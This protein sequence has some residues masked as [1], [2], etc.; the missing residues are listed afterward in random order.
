MVMSE[1]VLLLHLSDIH[2]R[3]SSDAILSRSGEIAA[4]TFKRLPEIT[5]VLMIVSGDIAYGGKKSEYDLATEFLANIAKSIRTQKD[6]I[7]VEVFVCPGN[8][9]CDFD[10]DDDTREAVLAKIRLSDSAPSESLIKTATSIQQA[11]FEFRDNVSAFA[12]VHASPMSWQ[13]VIKVGNHRIG[14]RS[15]NVAWMSEIKEK[16]GTLIFPPSEISPFKMREAD[17]SITILHHPYNWFGQSSYRA[18]Q[19][20]V[21]R[22]SQIVFTG[23]EHV[24]NVGEVSDSRNS[25]SVFVEGG[26]L[27]ESRLPERSTFNTI[28]VDLAKAEYLSELYSWDGKRYAADDDDEIWGSLRPLTVESEHKCSLQPMFLETLKDPGANFSHSSKKNLELDDFYIWPELQYLDDKATIKK[29]VL[30]SYF[31]DVANLNSG[32]FVRGDEK[33]GKTALLY[34]YF[35]SYFDRGYLP[36]YFRGAWFTK[37]HQS[38]PLKAL[39]FALERQYNKSCH[40]DFQQSR[41]EKRVL[42]L[43]DIDAST[44]PSAD[45]SE[46]ITNFFGYFDHIIVTGKD[47]TAAMD[48]LSIDRIEALRNFSQYEIREFGH[49]KR[50]ELVCKWA[51]I[52]GENDQNSA[53]WM[54]TIDK[55]EKDLTTAVGRQFVPAVPIFLLTLLQSIEAGRTADLQNSAF[56]HYYQFLITSALQG[57]GV[58]R[59]QWTEVF[60]YCANLAWFLQSSEQTFISVQNLRLF[61]EQFS[62]EFTPISF[63]RRL[64]DLTKAGIL[65]QNDGQIAFKYSYLYFYFVGQYIADQIHNP[66]M[67]NFVGLLCRNLHLSNNANILLFASHHTR[68]P[69]I[70]ERIAEALDNCFSKNPIFDFERDVGLLNSLV[71][72]APSLV[73]DERPVHE[74]RLMERERQDLLGDSPLEDETGNE[75]NAAI[76]R[77]FRSMEILGQF[78]KNHYGTTRNPVK[79]Q[80]IKKVIDGSLRGLY[81]ITSSL[82]DNTALL[83]EHVGRDAD[84]AGE[85]KDERVSQMKKLLFDL[86]GLITF[87]FVHKA[88]SSI[89][90]VYL[91]E[92]LQKVVDESGSLGYELIA[93]SY[94]MDLPDRISFV[95]LKALNSTVSNNVFSRALLRTLALKHLHLFKVSYKDKQRLCEELDISLN[96][97]MALQ[98]SRRTQ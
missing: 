97:Q 64:V 80:L 54:S 91:R 14:V 85:S 77:L 48:L 50:F 2:I 93:M 17:L 51:E 7:A 55:W 70:Y 4:T 72:A 67:D 89:G 11:F 23:H 78:L 24:Q 96:Q 31:V 32:V 82:L 43:D 83:L 12:W 22:E 92:N 39:K 38:S 13:A 46:C 20:I 52:G 5:T 79:D 28:I 84:K 34:Q 44:L 90:S 16:Q 56:G 45:L 41:K 47:S 63:E 25:S 60:N 98:H 1:K 74:S 8:H 95:K 71:N 15:L 53:K 27:F 37:A 10:N 33:A 21:R 18:L 86:M 62:R 88:S 66:E 94:Q 30:G 3:G 65:S 40:P 36:I 76:I 81:G 73:Y 26:V 61:T 68:S 59:E 49:K 29:N 69:L 75:T 6:D 42:L 19:N 87:A 57:E 35:S 58:D 9:D